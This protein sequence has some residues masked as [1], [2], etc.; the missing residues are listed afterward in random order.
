MYRPEYFIHE[1]AFRIRTYEIDERKTVSAP[2]LVRLMQETAMQHVLKLRLSVWDLESQNLAWVL[3]R[4]NIQVVRYP[5]LGEQIR[6]RTHPSGFEKIFTYRDFRIFDEQDQE[7]ASASTCWLL[8]NTRERKMTRIP[9]A[10]L[11]FNELLP[12]PATFLPR[13]DARAPAIENVD[14]SQ[15][16]TVQRHEL[17]FN[18]HLN[19]TFYIQW[20][21]EALPE[22]VLTRASMQKMDLIYRTE[23]YWRDEVVAETQQMDSALFHHRLRRPADD[24]ELA[25]GRSIWKVQ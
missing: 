23:C 14:Y 12:D 24:Q 16:F 15:H 8:M 1:E 22:A 6:I 10:F 5:L 7:I 25:S 17:D 11:E 21:L 19:N 18:L 4:K 13:P 20:M 3:I 9:P 2:A